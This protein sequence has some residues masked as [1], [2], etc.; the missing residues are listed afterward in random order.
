MTFKS[1]VHK[2][3]PG[4]CDGVGVFVFGRNVVKQHIPR[5]GMGVVPENALRHTPYG[6]NVGGASNDRAV[7]P[8]PSTT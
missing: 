3:K 6:Y 7:D 8:R 4:L 5:V 1:A 2:Q